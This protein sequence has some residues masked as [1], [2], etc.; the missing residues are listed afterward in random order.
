VE[1]KEKGTLKRLPASPATSTD[2]L[3]GKTIANLIILGL[4]AVIII[5][6]GLGCG[7]KI[8][9]NPT[10]PEHWLIP[11]LLILVLIFVIGLGMLLSLVVR[12]IKGASGISIFL[13]L[14][15]AFLAGIWFP[16]WMLP[17]W[18]R[19][20][21]DLFPATWAI[22][23]M[24][25]IMVYELPLTGVLPDVIK[26]LVATIVTYALGVLAYK[27]VLRKYAEL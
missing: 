21:G 26:V 18:L 15:L 10:S 27:R 7:A 13:G 20:L 11:F 6:V 17:P 9:R 24:R 5:L 22:D 16:K 4:T 19:V 3:I 23:A 1:E 25:S 12:T 8:L 14:M 2:M